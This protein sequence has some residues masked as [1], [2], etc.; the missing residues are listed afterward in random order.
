MSIGVLLVLL[1]DV[2]SSRER[3]PTPVLYPSL[4]YPSILRTSNLFDHCCE[5]QYWIFTSREK[6]RAVF[7]CN[8]IGVNGFLLINGRQLK[9]LCQRRECLV[10]P[11]RHSASR[12][13]SGINCCERLLIIFFEK[14][15]LC[16]D[17]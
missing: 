10:V 14:I 11:H 17:P 15:K 4:R 3:F 13:H 6:L 16:C 8:L 1:E 7:L 12:C 9:P 2:K 5:D